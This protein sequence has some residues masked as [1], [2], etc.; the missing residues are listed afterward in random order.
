MTRGKHGLKILGLSLLIA[1][2]ASAC[3]AALAQAAE[4]KIEGISFL[5]LGIEQEE[6][7]EEATSETFTFDIPPGA[8][9]NCL[10]RTLTSPQSW[11]LWFS[12]GNTHRLLSLTMCT[13]LDAMNNELPC[14][15]VEPL[16]FKILGSRVSH[17]GKV[18]ELLEG[19]E[20]GAMGTLRL[21]GA[22]C[23][24]PREFA[25][26]GTLAA[27]TEEGERVEQ[28]LTYSPAINALLGTKLFFGKREAGVSGK[29][30]V[31]LAGK[32]KGKKW[33]YS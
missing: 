17:A 15:V 7:Q 11:A 5:E 30:V 18:Y 21:E 4:F 6:L 31:K 23:A 22:I 12:G 26:T 2:G 33:G 24:L 3:T 19:S 1:L 10:L 25:V 29:T 13:V 14:T 9:I 20:G 28:T 16:H 27:E 8:K 32:N